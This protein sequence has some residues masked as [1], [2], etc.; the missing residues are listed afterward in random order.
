MVIQTVPQPIVPG[1]GANFCSGIEAY[2]MSRP[3]KSNAYTGISLAFFI[4]NV[5]LWGLS[6]FPLWFLRN[7]TRF[8]FIRPFFLSLVLCGAQIAFAMV[9]SL[10][11]IVENLLCR[12][13][14]FGI[15]VAFAC[16]GINYF[17]RLLIFVIQ[18]QFSRTMA[19]HKMET[20]AASEDNARAFSIASSNN[21]SNARSLTP[22][23]SFG[24][25]LV[26]ICK[27]IL[28]FIDLADVSFAELFATKGMFRALTLLV[29]LPALISIFTILGLFPQYRA[30]CS[31]CSIY[32]ELFVAFLAT[33]LFYIVISIRVLFSAW[34]LKFPDDQ[35]SLQ[36]FSATLV[37]VFGF[38]VFAAILM[39]IDPNRAAYNRQF[40][41]EWLF[42]VATIMYWYVAIGQQF[43]AVYKQSRIS[44]TTGHRAKVFNG[45]ESYL[46]ILASDPDAADAFTKFCVGR[47]AVENLYF[48]QDVQIYKKLYYDKAPNWRRQ[49]GNYILNTYL[50]HGGMMEVNISEK[51]Q[52]AA[53][54]RAQRTLANA[55]ADESDLFRVFDEPFDEIV[56][57][58]LR[59]MWQEFSY[60]FEPVRPSQLSSRA[61]MRSTLA[62]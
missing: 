14:L 18:S 53:V 20:G 1:G 38:M 34:R 5:T 4:I 28:G 47:Y 40:A 57:H 49:K 21:E 41:F 23:S 56:N 46:E 19:M 50:I 61:P 26:A 8:H 51:M 30:T 16:F 10:N 59:G 29:F 13:T 27:F 9:F 43:Y 24:A 55:S 32:L 6:L 17:I 33:L 35:G 36:E 52:T 60:T 25:S 11:L 31:A 7:H 3:A 39:L 45:Q 54:S 37:L 15:V 58:V 12:F 42:S 44:F 48:A 22:A 2:E 62:V